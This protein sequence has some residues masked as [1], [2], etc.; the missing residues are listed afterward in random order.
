[1]R[2][3]EIKPTPVSGIDLYRPHS[4]HTNHKCNKYN[5]FRILY[6][7]FRNL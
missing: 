4:R 7:L 2:K 5:L 1:M 6:T 3:I